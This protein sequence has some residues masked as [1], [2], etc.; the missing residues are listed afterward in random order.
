MSKLEI[1]TFKEENLCP[2]CS[3]RGFS[4][5]YCTK[6]CIPVSDIFYL[7]HFHKICNRCSYEWIEKVDAI[8]ISS[9]S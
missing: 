9:S 4:L 2:K 6:S 5:L 1:P 8:T 3:Y 7:E